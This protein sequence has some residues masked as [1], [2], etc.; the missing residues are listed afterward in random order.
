MAFYGIEL[1]RRTDWKQDLFVGISLG[2]AF[3]IGNLLTPAISI[4]MPSLSL[5]ATAFNRVLVIGLLAPIIEEAL[6]RGL[7]SGILSSK[8]INIKNTLVVGVVTALAFS[9]YHWTAYGET[10]AAS[11]AFFGAFIFGLV[12][13]FVT[14]KRKSLL[15]AMVLH[16][17]FNIY[18]LTRLFVVVG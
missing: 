12:A 16:S 6:F 1:G 8:L 14:Y 13:F 3:I 2:I 11:G 9:A 17:M 18:L 7:L 15:P 5:S 4:G 10:L